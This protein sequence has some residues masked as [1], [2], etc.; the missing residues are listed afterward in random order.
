M[1]G[2]NCLGQ[3]GLACQSPDLAVQCDFAPDSISSIKHASDS[4]GNLAQCR[5][6]TLQLLQELEGLT[7]KL[8]HAPC[9]FYAAA[10][11]LLSPDALLEV[12]I[13]YE[14]TADLPLR[15]LLPTGAA[16]VVAS[17][18][19]FPEDQIIPKG[20]LICEEGTTTLQTQWEHKAARYNAAMGHRWLYNQMGQ[21]Y[22]F[23]LSNIIVLLVFNGSD[24]QAYKP[25][26]VGTFNCPNAAVYISSAAPINQL[27]ELET[28]KALGAKEKEIEA[29]TAAVLR[30][31]EEI[32]A[33]KEEIEA[34]KAA[35]LWA[36]GEE[37]EALKAALRAKDEEIEAAKAQ[38]RAKELH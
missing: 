35:A 12:D 30:A 19:R 32:E 18:A 2:P 1:L 29:A 3:R 8:R 20:T 26:Y 28:R 27:I 6:R 21:P 23:N 11:A 4:G 36:K 15:C 37:I 22:P 7:I 9:T 10:G 33:A 14:A 34:A 24:P 31:K 17:H 16:H 38:A 25:Q 13:I 5:L